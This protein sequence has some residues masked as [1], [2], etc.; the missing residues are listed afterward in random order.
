MH[1]TPV[2]FSPQPCCP[3]CDKLVKWYHMGRRSQSPA[4]S[5]PV[6]IAQV[7]GTFSPLNL[8]VQMLTICLLCTP[9]AAEG[10][11]GTE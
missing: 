3:L 6:P 5:L 1:P 4:Y 9:Q 11:M 7:S 8:L 10:K 2:S